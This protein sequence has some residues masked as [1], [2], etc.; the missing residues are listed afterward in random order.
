MRLHLPISIGAIALLLSVSTFALDGI[1]S[2]SQEV[3]ALLRTLQYS[4][5]QFNRNGQWYSAGEA[6]AHL[7]SK[8]EYLHAKETINSTEDFIELA[9]SNSSLSGVPYKVKCGDQGVVT[10]HKWLTEQ[11]NILRTRK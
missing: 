5:C 11:L 3:D 2:I 8:L 10:S 4:R 9:A 7:K 1:R 6:T